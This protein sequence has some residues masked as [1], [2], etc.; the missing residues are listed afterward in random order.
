MAVGGDGTV[1]EVVNGLV[2]P[3]GLTRAALGRLFTGRGCGLGRNLGLPRDLAEACRRLAAGA[4]VAVDVGVARWERRTERCFAG[5]LGAG[6][7]AAAPLPVHR[8]GEPCGVAP[9][10]V[11]VLPRALRVLVQRTFRISRGPGPA[12]SRLPRPVFDS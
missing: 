12:I 2:A 5:S 8:D 11:S 6:F 9:V 10:R 7:D 3:G 4:E 1:N